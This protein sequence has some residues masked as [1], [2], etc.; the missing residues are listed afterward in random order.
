MDHEEL[1]IEVFNDKRFG[2]GSGRKNHFLGRVKLTA[3][4][5]PGAA[6]RGSSTSRS[7]RRASSAGS[8]ARSGC[9]SVTTTRSES[10]A[11]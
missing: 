9:G 8:A 4:S 1:D 10:K 3:L 2:N 7:R 6:T 5:S 11:N